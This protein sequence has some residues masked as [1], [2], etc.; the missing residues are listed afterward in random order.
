MAPQE[1]LFH[2]FQ[3]LAVLG[4]F[5]INGGSQQVAD[6][7]FFQLRV[8]EQNFVYPIEVVDQTVMQLNVVLAENQRGRQ[9]RDEFFAFTHV[10]DPVLAGCERLLGG[11]RRARSAKKPPSRHEEATRQGFHINIVSQP[12]AALIRLVS[13]DMMPDIV[14]KKDLKEQLEAASGKLQA[15]GRFL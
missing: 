11:K 1:I 9:E 15:L 6:V 12:A 3:G 5:Q 7:F 8:F 13:C 10:F 4:L 14:N 2:G